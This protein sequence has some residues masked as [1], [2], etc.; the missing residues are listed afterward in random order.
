MHSPHERMVVLPGQGK[1]VA[2]GGIGVIFKVYGEETGG[3]LAIVEHPL[4]PGTLVP[5]HTHAGEDEL[6]YVLEGEFGVRVG[7]R[8]LEAGP[9]SYVFKPRGIPHTFWNAGPAP[10]RLI[11]LITPAGFEHFFEEMAALFPAGGL[12]DFEQVVK[13]GRRYNHSFGPDEWIP[14]LAAKYHLTLFGR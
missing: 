3:R 2:L 9:G 6:S 10:A 8:V 1:A 4:E 14:E 7:D 12:P 13:L 11:E 5:P